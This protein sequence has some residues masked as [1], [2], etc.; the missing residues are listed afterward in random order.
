MCRGI[1]HLLGGFS[2]HGELVA[3]SIW[4]QGHFMASHHPNTMETS[5]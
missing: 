5:S 2:I 1:K 3:E 4:G